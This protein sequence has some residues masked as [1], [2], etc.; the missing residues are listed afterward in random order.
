MLVEVSGGLLGIV[1]A[2]VAVLLGLV[3]WKCVRK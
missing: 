1:A 3:G 2:I